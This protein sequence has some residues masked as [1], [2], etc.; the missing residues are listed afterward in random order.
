MKNQVKRTPV[1]LHA[2]RLV[3]P[4]A[5]SFLVLVLT[6]WIARGTLDAETFDQYI[7]PHAEAYGL[8]WLLLA[9]L[10]IRSASAISGGATAP[11]RKAAQDKAGHECAPQSQ[12]AFGCACRRQ[13]KYVHLS[14][15]LF[16]F[17]NY[18]PRKP[19]SFLSRDG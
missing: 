18:A 8:A 5:V 14:Y 12:V 11:L 6:E 16:P 10:A 9:A 2:A 4:V 1:L 7:F 17:L 19:S 3:F 15:L 13:H